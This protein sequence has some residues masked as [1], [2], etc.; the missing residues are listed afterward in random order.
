MTWRTDCTAFSRRSDRDDTFVEILFEIV[1]DAF[2]D[3]RGQPPF[4]VAGAL[5]GARK[6][7]R[8]PAALERNDL[9]I[10]EAHERQVVRQD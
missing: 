10:A 8:K 5:R 9:A 7:S 4:L 6:G 1:G 3:V 2:G